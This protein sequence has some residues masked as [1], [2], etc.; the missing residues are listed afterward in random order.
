MKGPRIGI[1]ALI[2]PG[3]LVAATGV[4]AGDLATAGFTGAMLGTGVAWAVLLGAILKYVLTE[5]LAR[6]QLSTNSTLLEGVGRHVG[7]WALVV[8]L[9]YL[10][11]FSY[12]VGGAL[13]SA[14]GITTQSI[15][16]L[17]DDPQAG[18]IMY[19]S[20]ISFV[21]LMIAWIG[22]FKLFERVMAMCIAVMFVAVLVTALLLVPDWGDLFGGMIVS[23]TIPDPSGESFTWTL[24]LLGGVG[25]T[26]T[27]LCYGYWIRQQGRFGTQWIRT[28]RIDLAVGYLFTGIFGVAMLVIATDTDPSARGA[29]LIVELASR[30]DHQLGSWARWIFLIGAWAAVTS[31]LLGVWQAVPMLFADAWRSIFGLRR[32]DADALVKTASARIFLVLMA[33]LPIMQA[34]QSFKEVQKIYAVLGAFFLP[35]LALALLWLNGQTRMV[36]R[37]RRN[38]PVTVALL[39]LTLGVFAVYGWLKVR[40]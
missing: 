36:G 16:P 1:L 30:L 2:G 15:I 12:V 17:G 5:G 19:G 7:P 25:G 27:L 34:W 4:G 14:C 28:C 35:L 31:S 18:K 6:W 11:P 22:G 37:D 33:T 26:V 40:R 10:I 39:I 8:F 32:L 29:N 13:I 23:P 9:V 20:I 21:G 24:S 38:G 3:L